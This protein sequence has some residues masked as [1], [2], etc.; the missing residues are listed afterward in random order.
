MDREHVVLLGALIA[1]MERR[2]P[3]VVKD[4]AELLRDIDTSGMEHRRIREITD[5]RWWLYRN[6]SGEVPNPAV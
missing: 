3:G 2:Q 6:Y 1:V 4:M 5:A